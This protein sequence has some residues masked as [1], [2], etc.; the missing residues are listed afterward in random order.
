MAVKTFGAVVV[1][2]IHDRL[3]RNRRNVNDRTRG[4]FTSNDAESGG[5]KR[6]TGHPGHG[7]L[8]QNGVEDTVGNLVSDLVGMSFRHGF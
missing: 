5:E 4:D 7:I 6:F 2:N 3:S 8:R 1:A